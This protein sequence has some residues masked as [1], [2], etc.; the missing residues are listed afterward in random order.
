MKK[1]CDILLIDDDENIHRIVKQR[2]A[3]ESWIIRSAFDKESAITALS[4]TPDLVLLD[5]RLPHDKEGLSLLKKIRKLIPVT[6]VIMLSSR[7]EVETVVDALRSGA[8]DYFHKPELADKDKFSNFINNILEECKKGLQRKLTYS[9]PGFDDIIGRSNSIH[10]M[11]KLSRLVAPED[12]NVLLTGETGTGKEILSRAIHRNSL[13][14][15]GP[16]ISINSSAI[17]EQ[18]AESELFG[19]TKGAFT[20]AIQSK[21][22]K[23]ELAHNGT[24]FLDEIGEMSLVLQSKI[25]KAIEDKIITPIGSNQQIEVNCRI[26]SAT[27]CNLLK[28]VKQKRFRED[29]YYRLHGFPIEIPSLK[30]RKDDI[31]LLVNHFINKHRPNKDQSI[32]TSAL[33]ALENIS[34]P[35]NIRQLEN[36]I[37]YAL[38]VSKNQNIDVE[39]FPLLRER[40]QPVEVITLSEAE[41]RA[42]EAALKGAKNK[43]EAARILDISRPTLNKKI[44]DLNIHIK[45]D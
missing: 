10:K 33:K 13:H 7:R 45:K 8:T 23:F 6:P 34:Y 16:F 14:S 9:E 38:I 20:G 35:G 2:F 30:E 4:Q 41:K 43:S 11:L 26:I 31:P 19:H 37:Q 27:N 5:I 22:G 21:K 44:K 42:I 12:I 40:E 25:L 15:K 39:H 17:P 3:K 28:E 1:N 18:L 36:M 24:L 32:T 29:L